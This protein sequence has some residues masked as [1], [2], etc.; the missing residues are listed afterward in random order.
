MISSSKS[1]CG[2]VTGTR[3]PIRITSRCVDRREVLDEEGELLG[4]EGER[5]AAGDDH[6]A[7]LG[8]V[9]DVLDHPLVVARDRVPA[10]PLHRGP[11]AGAEP[12]IHG[13]DVG[14]D[15]QGPVGVAVGQAGDGRI[16][17]L[18][19]RVV[20]LG[21]DRA[22]A[23]PAA[24]G[25]TGAG[26]GRAGRRGRSA[27][28]NRAGSPACTAVVR[29]SSAARSSGENGSSSAS[30]LAWRTAFWACHRQ[31]VHWASG[32]WAQA[33]CRGVEVVGPGTGRLV[34]V[35]ELGPGGDGDEWGRGARGIAHR[36]A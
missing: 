22:R 11:L 23:V 2:R 17:V 28:S 9:A 35:R 30:C 16:L 8:V 33:G 24:R 25:P 5:V 31:S 10:A 27:R 34:A 32:T 21:P 36:I 20:F 15:Q 19:E 26:S 18:V 3:V 7:D 6:V 14:R 4:R 1:R 13:A 29:T 12:A